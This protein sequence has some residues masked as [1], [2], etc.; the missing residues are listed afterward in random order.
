MNPAL[1]AYLNA[2]I[3]RKVALA[4]T[5]SQGATQLYF[6]IRALK[7]LEREANTI[8]ADQNERLHIYNEALQILLPE[9]AP[10]TL[11]KLDQGLEFWAIIRGRSAQ[12][13]K[14]DES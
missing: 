7:K 11:A 1:E 4:V 6:A 13:P 9:A 5:V 12:H 10:E 8:I 14:D 3:P 2:P